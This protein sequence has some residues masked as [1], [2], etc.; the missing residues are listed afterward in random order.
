MTMTGDD[1]SRP[2]YLRIAD[3]LRDKVAS[4]ELAEGARVDSESQLVDRWGTTRSTVR[5][6]LD[7]LRVEGLIV[8]QHGRGAFVRRRPAVEVR[9]SS[10]YLRRPAGETSPFAKDARREGAEPDWTSET[11]RVRTDE[12]V[13]ARLGL[14]AGEHVMRTRYLFRADGRP[15]QTSVSWEPFTLVGGTAVEEPEGGGPVGVVARMDSIGVHVDR[16]VEMVRAR[17]ASESERRE[18]DVPE[19][20]WVVAVERTHWAGERAVETADIVIPADRYVLAYEIPVP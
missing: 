6:A 9:W 10:R 17:P 20:V 16:V 8:K 14:V 12:R 1:Q 18:L 7:V 5:Q 11:Q 15:V 19:G 13:A 2:L 4:G 3:D